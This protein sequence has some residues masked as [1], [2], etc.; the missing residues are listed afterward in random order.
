MKV[1]SIQLKHIGHFTDIQIPF[2]LQDTAITIISGPQGSGKSLILKHLYQ[3]LTWF[4]ARYRDP[5]NAGVVISDQD[6]LLNRLQAKVDIQVKIPAE[7][8][9]LPESSDKTSVLTAQCQWQ[10]YKTLTGNGTGIS[11]V[12]TQQ[13]EA[14]TVLYQHAVKQDPLQGLPLIAY[15]PADRFIHEINLL[16]KNNPAVFQLSHAYDN[17]IIPFTT[18]SRFFEWLREVSDCENAQ[19]AQLLQQWLD[20]QSQAPSSHSQTLW[21]T[22]AQL[23][24]PG[25]KALRDALQTVLPEIEQLYIQYHPA[26]QLMVRYQGKTM[27]YQQLPG[28]LKNWIALTGDIVRRLC[29]LNPLSLYPC[30]EGEGVLIIDAV[31]NGLDETH[32]MEILDRLHRAFPQLQIIVSC[33]RHEVIESAEQY[34]CFRIEQQQLHEVNFHQF[35]SEFQHLYQEIMQSAE[36]RLNLNDPSSIESDRIHHILE[37]IQTLNPAE[38]EQLLMLIQSDDDT[39]SHEHLQ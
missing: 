12:E 6:I 23:H 11:K 16:S 31:D 39:S 37:Q 21:Q 29:L 19:T 13:L 25:L 20:E 35:S 15:Y 32:S 4:S 17:A 14:L 5:R 38:Q 30:L 3:S 36:E 26:L 2:R 34:Q 7:V 8:G 28:S 22:H 10:L 1:K 24:A 18:F 27:L 9:Q 33:C